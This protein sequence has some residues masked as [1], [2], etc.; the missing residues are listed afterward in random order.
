[1][2]TIFYVRKS[3]QAERI[4]SSREVSVEDVINLYGSAPANYLFMKGAE[5]PLDNTGRGPAEFFSDPD[6]AVVKIDQTETN[7]EIF[8]E[9]GFYIGKEAR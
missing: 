7:Q 2:A 4:A 8:P 6:R 9:D 3:S 5:S 1:M